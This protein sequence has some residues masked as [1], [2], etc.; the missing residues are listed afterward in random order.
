MIQT[1]VFQVEGNTSATAEGL[2]VAAACLQDG[3]LVA[4]P[5]ET[6]YGLGA[7]ALIPSAI[8]KIYWAKGRPSNNPLIV[9]F[10][11]L[12][13]LSALAVN[14][15]QVAWDLAERFWPGPL[16]FVLPRNPAVPALVSAG[17]E[18]IAVRIPAHPVALALLELAAVPV[19]APSANRSTRPSA[20]SAAHVLADLGGRVDVILD[21]GMAS[22]GLESTVIDLT[23]ETPLLLRPGGVSLET[24][25]E[26]LPNIVRYLPEGQTDADAEP[27]SP[28]LLY[29]H[30][31]PKA[32]VLLF[33]GEDSAVTVR[34]LLEV[35]QQ[36][37]QGQRVGL[38]LVEQ[39]IADFEGLDVVIEP[40][41]PRGD[42]ETLA[43]TLFAHLRGLDAQNVD[44]I[45]VQQVKNEGLGAAIADRLSRA[46]EGNLIKV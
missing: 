46:A 41:G 16:T 40:L 8:E 37:A 39:A 21:A 11:D 36:Q 3:G 30:Y 2:T 25:R 28:G 9:H 10:A 14:V 17:R 13:Q 20:T 22:I 15:P 38:L 19:A 4:F 34:M 32:K 18:T 31:A 35:A 6:V 23:H 33:E 27:V 42:L 5:T 45:L 26:V 29:K 7:N 44:V 1:K 43:H 12:A 24:L